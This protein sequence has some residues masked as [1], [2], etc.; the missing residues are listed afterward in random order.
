MISIYN[1]S[2]TPRLHYVAKL[3]F[4][5]LQKTDW[6]ILDT[7]EEFSSAQGFKINYSE[8]ELSCNV[9]WIPHELLCN[10]ELLPYDVSVDTWRDFPILFPADDKLWPFDLFAATFFL[11]SRYEEYLP[12]EADAHGRFP[13]AQ[14]VAY[15]HEFLERPLIDEW[16]KAFAKMVRE[17]SGI[18][19][20]KRHFTAEATFDIDVAWAYRHKGWWRTIAAFGMDVFQRRFN[21]MGERW[22]AVAGG[23]SDP[24]DTYDFIRAEVEKHQV[25]ARFFI[26]LGDYSKQDR[27]SSHQL[28]AMQQLIRQLG[29]F[30]SV[31]IHPSYGSHK[32]Q[33]QLEKEIARL[34][35]ICDNDIRD[36]RQ[37]Y[38]KMTMPE[39]YQRLIKA[40]IRR[41]YTM[42]YAQHVGFRASLCTPFPFFD[43]LADRETDLWIYP[44]AYMD[45]TLRQYM[46]LSTDEAIDYVHRL[47]KSVKAVDG[48]FSCLWHNSSLSDRAEW[49][50]W[51]KVFEATLEAVEDTN[52][53]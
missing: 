48:Y 8:E 3:L 50:G 13:A 4:G 39:T 30:A 33:N 21:R 42:G 29:E 49:K 36:S 51:R 43:L 40:G 52:A 37:H 45:G 38:L 35:A 17:Q 47:T 41:D 34:A 18:Q 26:L 27:N 5:V 31:G 15:H 6:Q 53:D 24:Y 2:P 10:S 19:F 9:G 20:E 23:A 28:P 44:F 32:S 11:A 1:P 12:H 46:S 7:S 16:A 14:S 25:P 22:S